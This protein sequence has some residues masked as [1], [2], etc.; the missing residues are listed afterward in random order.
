MATSHKNPAF[1]EP[2]KVLCPHC[3]KMHQVRA[4][5]LGRLTKCTSCQQQFVLRR[6]EESV[7]DSNGPN[8]VHKPPIAPKSPA[9]ASPPSR[10]KTSAEQEAIAENELEQLLESPPPTMTAPPVPPPAVLPPAKPTAIDNHAAAGV[11]SGCESVHH[12]HQIQLPQFELPLREKVSHLAGWAV[13]I[14]VFSV[15]IVVV[16]AT[17]WFTV[18]LALSIAARFFS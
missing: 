9:K 16:W 10:P 4:S 1:A 17:L 14:A 18:A 6:I 12:T 7:S 11:A 13:A 2:A 8:A 5:V 15:V 3:E